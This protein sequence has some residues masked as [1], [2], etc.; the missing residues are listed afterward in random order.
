MSTHSPL[1]MKAIIDSNKDTRARIA[2]PRSFRV[3][4]RSGRSKGTFARRARVTLARAH[5]FPERAHGIVMMMTHTSRAMAV[6]PATR[7]AKAR[8]RGIA[9]RG[10][11]R[12]ARAEV[13]VTAEKGVEDALRR[14]QVRARA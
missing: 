5:A 13:A 7:V 12:P 8:G 1:P 10:L 11:A 9:A 2:D 14:G 3:A 4:S 6:T